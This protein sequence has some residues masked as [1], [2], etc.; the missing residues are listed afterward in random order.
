V[1]LAHE[2]VELPAVSFTAPPRNSYDYRLVVSRK[3]YDRAVGTAMSRSLAKLAP[4]ASAHVHPLDLDA[5]GVATG[6]DVKLVSAKAST[7]LPIV[8][9]TAVP[10]GTVWAPFNQPGG[11][12]EEIIDAAAAVT[13]V[14]IE[15]V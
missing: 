10:R 5:L 4:G 7:V 13:D 14:R 15:R 8:A 3:L 6:D 2:S 9:D 12:V 1:V 11:T